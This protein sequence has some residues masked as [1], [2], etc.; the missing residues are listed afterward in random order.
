MCECPV[1]GC[2]GGQY[3]TKRAFNWPISPC[4]SGSLCAVQA[5]HIVQ[6]LGKCKIR[7]D[8]QH[9][10]LG[11]QHHVHDRHRAGG[12]RALDESH[13]RC[14]QKF[15]IL[16]I[17]VCGAVSTSGAGYNERQGLKCPR[18]GEGRDAQS[19]ASISLQYS[20]LTAWPTHRV[21]RQ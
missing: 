8:Q 11:F 19:S 18:A 17:L 15:T 1:V 5:I 10:P 13:S 3:L 6:L 4:P 14:M 2:H 21:N 7:H 9:D 12:Y 16:G 20:I